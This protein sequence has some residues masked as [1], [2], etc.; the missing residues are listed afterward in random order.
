[1]YLLF[2]RAWPPPTNAMVY[3]IH[4]FSVGAG[5]ACDHDCSEQIPNAV[6][7]PDLLHTFR[8][9]EVTNVMKSTAL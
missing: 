6:T 3:S 5:H 1:M 4:R 7:L 8:G 9:L 2:S